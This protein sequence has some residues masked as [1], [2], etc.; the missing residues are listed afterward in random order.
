MVQS[1]SGDDD[2]AT[3]VGSNTTGS[4]NTGSWFH[5][6]HEFTTNDSMTGNWTLLDPRGFVPPYLSF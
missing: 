6:R 3:T 5:D 4:T 1:G 2:D